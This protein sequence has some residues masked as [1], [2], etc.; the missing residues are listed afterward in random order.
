MHPHRHT[1]PT[2]KLNT[3]LTAQPPPA[4]THH[5]RHGAPRV[6]RLTEVGSYEQV[7][8]AEIADLREVVSANSQAALLH[9][10]PCLPTVSPAGGLFSPDP[11][12]CVPPS[13]PHH[14]PGPGSPGGGGPR[15]CCKLPAQP[16]PIRDASMRGTLSGT[17]TIPRPPWLRSPCGPSPE[18]PPPLAPRAEGAHT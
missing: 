18:P 2:T 3:W 12:P 11:T 6:S 5:V 17:A 1:D 8:Q 4:P 7:R 15:M 9:T 14:E 16:A 13:C 10:V